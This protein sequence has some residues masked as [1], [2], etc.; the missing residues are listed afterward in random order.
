MRHRRCRRAAD[1]RPHPSSTTGLGA[2]PTGPG[3]RGTTIRLRLPAGLP[4]GAF[5]YAGWEL[6][7]DMAEETKD[8]PNTAARTMLWSIGAVAVSG[9]AMVI[10]FSYAS[11]GLAETLQSATPALSVVDYQFGHT[12]AEVYNALLLVTFFAVALLITA[13][14]TRLLFS[15]ARDGLPPGAALFKKVNSRKTPAAATI[16]VGI[17]AIVM[18][19]V[20]QLYSTNVQNTIF[21]TASVG[22]NLVYT[23]VAAIFLYKAAK[24]EL[25]RSFGKFS[26]GK[27]AKPVAL[28]A[29][30]WQLFVVGTLTFPAANHQTAW[31]ALIF[32]GLGA[33]WYLVWILPRSRRAE[34]QNG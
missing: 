1:R 9:I 30:L 33:V 11:P 21:G 28:I 14:A 2:V 4:A 17:F 13:G 26:L 22:Y 20:P 5:L 8:A 10:A 6:P 29:L 16:C 24:D 12:V 23:L 15:M 25:P 7:A 18:F 19:T 32:I 3:H 34:H 31:T 27:W